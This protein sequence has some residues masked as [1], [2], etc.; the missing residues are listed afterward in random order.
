MISVIMPVYNAER[1]LNFSIKS[2]LKQTYSDFEFIIINDGS[3][4]NSMNIINHYEKIDNRIKVINQKNLGVTRA[5]INGIKN[6]K[7]KYIARMDAD[8]ISLPQR[9]A[10]QIVWINKYNFDFCCSRTYWINKRQ[11]SNI[12]YCY[13]PFYI[14]IKY[15]NPFIHGTYFFLL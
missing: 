12:L 10:Q 8:D 7:G 5:L 9:F 14:S 3:T 13:I 1:F 6:S 11:N 2:I 4:D 15:T